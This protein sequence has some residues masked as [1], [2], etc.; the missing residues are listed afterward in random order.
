MTQRN[1]A[2]LV[3]FLVPFFALA[4]HQWAW[5]PGATDGD[6]AQYLLHAKALVEG[7]P[8]AETGYIVH[9][10]AWSIGPRAYPPGLP[11]TLAPLVAAVG[12]HSSL[13][14]VLMLASMAMFAVLAW[15]RLAIDVD[16]W[17]AAVGAGFAVFV[18]EARGGALAPISDPGFA[19]LMWGTILAV[20][21]TA[22]WSWRR[23][24]VV[25]AL[26]GATLAYR[27]TGIAVIGALA[28]HALATWRSHRGRAAIPIALLAL[29]G[30]VA[31][32]TG[33][34]QL[35][36][37]T[38]LW[39]GRWDVVA[40]AT[41]LRNQ[42]QSALFEMSLYPTPF[43]SANLAYHLAAACVMIAGLALMWRWLWRSFLAIACGVY[44]VMLLVSPVGEA[45]YV[46][47]LYPVGAC[48][49]AVGLTSLLRLTERRWPVVPASRLALVTLGVVAV[50]ALYS[51]SLRPPPKALVGTADAEALFAWLRQTKTTMP[52][53]IAFT[54]PRVVTLETGVPGMGNVGR[55]AAGHLLAYAE[56][57][58]THL[59]WQP[60]ERSDCR[61]RIAN[62]LPSLYPNRFELSYGNPSFRVYRVLPGPVPPV[63]T[64]TMRLS[65]RALESC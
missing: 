7:R 34:V 16:P 10:D 65:W 62:T 26:A 24:L 50:S 52:M 27:I 40:R 44:V 19:A 56:R 12:V 42:Y 36:D 28:L 6:Y 13:F 32:A 39:R 60:D 15:R 5:S 31:L 45:R 51:E 29:G 63:D 54:N 1:A 14:R 61:Q 48:A 37:L 2:W 58:I 43:S 35:G 53:R 41:M 46:W 25:T 22:S 18:V 17:Q 49:L 47:P 8:Y 38:T 23:I 21:T 57:D 55:K 20:D 30:L 33:L 64:S 9:P 4:I 59:I 11:L 3:A